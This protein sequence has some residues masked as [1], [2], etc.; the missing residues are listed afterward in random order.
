MQDIRFRT[1]TADDAPDLANV[2]QETFVA[3]FGHLYKAEDLA[4]FLGND[5]LGRWRDRLAD[6]ETDIRV[7]ELDGRLLGYGTLSSLSLPVT[8]SG[9]ALELSQLYLHQTLHGTGAAQILMEWVVARAQSRG[10]AELYLSVYIDNHRARRFYERYAFTEV[11][12]YIFKV[13]NHEDQDILMRRS[14]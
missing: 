7:A 2:Y 5:T 11:G 10:A 6:P 13:G 8:P 4:A 1:G 3:T 14:L 9:P 12:P